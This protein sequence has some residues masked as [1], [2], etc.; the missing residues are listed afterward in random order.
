MKK[1]IC[2]A[3]LV[4]VMGCLFALELSNSTFIGGVSFD[5]ITAN[6][7]DFKSV[8]HG[9]NQPFT[10]TVAGL[11]VYGGY[12][13]RV[14]SRWFTRLEYEIL[15]LPTRFDFVDEDIDKDAGVKRSGSKKR[16]GGY[17]TLGKDSQIKVNLGGV[18]TNITMGISGDYTGG[19]FEHVQNLY[20]LGLI[21]EGQ[22]NL[23]NHFTLRFGIVP[24]FTFMTIDRLD[25]SYQDADLSVDNDSTYRTTLFDFGFSISARM[26]VS[27]KF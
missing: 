27:Y 6:G 8:E 26:G 15:M 12:D 25:I 17:V 16:F 23:G 2:I 18:V 20:G 10:T 11:S 14:G 1:V 7:H 21:L 9:G 24:D 3:A 4:L 5:Y 19:K 13:V 22:Y